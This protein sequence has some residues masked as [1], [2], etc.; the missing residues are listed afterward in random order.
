MPE[1]L[2][3]FDAADE[4]RRGASQAAQHADAVLPD[5]SERALSLLRGF[6]LNRPYFLVEDVRHYAMQRGFPAPPDNRAW[7]AIVT[8]AAK[9]GFVRPDGTSRTKRGPGH[10]R[11]VTRWRSLLCEEFRP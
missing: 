4:A 10:A 6:A 9:A 2:F 5:W 8:Q 3:M 7:G 1:Q 11:P